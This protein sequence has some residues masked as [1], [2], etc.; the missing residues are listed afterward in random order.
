M[1]TVLQCEIT[2]LP[3]G[4]VLGRLHAKPEEPWWVWRGSG[5]L[6]LGDRYHT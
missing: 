2:R 6:P 3:V 5:S 1:D 4:V